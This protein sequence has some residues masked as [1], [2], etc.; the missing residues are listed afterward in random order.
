MMLNLYHARANIHTEICAQIYRENYVEEYKMQKRKNFIPG[1]VLALAI[2]LASTSSMLAQVQLTDCMEC[3]NDTTVITDKQVGVSE[4][5]HGTGEAYGAVQH[6]RQQC[7]AA[8][9]SL[10]RA[11]CPA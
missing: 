11:G 7:Y 3:H 5:V 1:L 6:G 8:N 4:A 10:R 9:H 2:L